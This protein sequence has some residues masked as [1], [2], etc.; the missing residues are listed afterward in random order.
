MLAGI[1]SAN[2]FKLRDVLSGT[3]AG[4]TMEG[5]GRAGNSSE[6]SALTPLGSR[7]SM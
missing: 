4:S 2:A 3:P 1:C 6:T 7:E 5:P